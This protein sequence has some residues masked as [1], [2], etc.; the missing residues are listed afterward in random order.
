[1][2]KMLIDVDEW[3]PVYSIIKPYKNGYNSGFEVE[4]PADLQERHDR[5][6]AEFDALQKELAKLSGRNG[7]AT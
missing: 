5:I 3:Y 1:M 2:T 4:I 6:M 7:D